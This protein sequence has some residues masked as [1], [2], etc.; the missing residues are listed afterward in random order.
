LFCIWAIKR[1]WSIE[2]TAARLLEVSPKAQERKEIK[3]DEGYAQWTAK[4]A[5]AA[6]ARERPPRLS[7]KPSP[8][9]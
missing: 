6:V 8:A 4:N 1:G 2:E 3:K 5:A 9:A 7:P